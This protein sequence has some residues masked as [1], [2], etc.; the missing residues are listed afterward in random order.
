MY[1]CILFVYLLFIYIHFQCIYL[2]IYLFVYLLIHLFRYYED[3]HTIDWLR[4]KTKDHLRH[5][6]IEN[7]KKTSIGAFFNK[8][9]DAASGWILVFLVG[10]A[11]GLLAG[12][13]LNI[14]IIMYIFV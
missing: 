12:G 7:K 14:I 11:S 8:Y 4:D 6:I 1:I 5:K 2:F 10:V 3:F 9:L 13:E